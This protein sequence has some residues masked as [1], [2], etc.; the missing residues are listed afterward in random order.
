MFYSKSTGGFYDTD[1]HGGSIPADAVEISVEQWQ[2]LLE[3]QTNGK[4]ITCDD[5]GNVVSAEPSPQEEV[6]LPQPTKEDLMSKLLEIQAQLE[7]LK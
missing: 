3:D 5:N 1:V 2:Q 7:A 4:V 6:V